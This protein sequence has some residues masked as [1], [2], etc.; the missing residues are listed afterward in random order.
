[1]D[2]TAPSSNPF[3]QVPIEITISVGKARP[4]VR[5]LLRMK[6]DSILPLDRRVED[7]VELYVGDKLIARG[8]LT[9]MEGD[10]NG[11]LAVRLTEVV[12]LQNGL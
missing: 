12:D 2:D 6:R 11:Q 7:P 10:S 8:E 3:S 9:E 1:M 4:L 5:D